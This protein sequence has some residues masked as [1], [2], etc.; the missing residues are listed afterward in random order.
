MSNSLVLVINSGSSSLK[1]AVIDANTGDDIVTGLGE[2]FGGEIL[3]ETETTTYCSTDYL[4]ETELCNGYDE[5]CDG[6]TDEDY[7]VG[8]ECGVGACA[9]GEMVCDTETSSVC[10]TNHYASPETCDGLDNDCDGSTDEDLTQSCGSGGCE[11]TQTCTAGNWSECSSKNNDCGICCVCEDNNDPEP[12][13]DGTQGDDC[14]DG[15]DCTLDSCGGLSVCTYTPNDGSCEDGNQ[16]TAN[17]CSVESG[18]SNPPLTGEACWDISFGDGICDN[19]GNC[20]DV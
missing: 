14:D 6:L 16:C 9:G 19:N 10:N 1:F 3:C 13:Y 15:I 12:I 17:I 5:D 18:C 8:D 20:V 2:C 11:G 7:F 4:I